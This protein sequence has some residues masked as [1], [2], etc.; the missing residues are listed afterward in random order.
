MAI[1]KKVVKRETAVPAVQFN[2]KIHTLNKM[3]I[4]TIWCMCLYH[5]ILYIQKHINIS[6]KVIHFVVSGL[7]LRRQLLFGLRWRQASPAE[8]PLAGWLAGWLWQF[9][10]TG[11]AHS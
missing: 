10:G 6:V 4:R 8:S 3:H 5:D 7:S 1:F 11:S 9:N 2:A